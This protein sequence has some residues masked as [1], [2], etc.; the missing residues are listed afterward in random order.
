MT[1]EIFA[2]VED[3]VAIYDRCKVEQNPNTHW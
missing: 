2:E 3:E 1:C